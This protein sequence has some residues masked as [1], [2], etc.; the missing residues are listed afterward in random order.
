MA[1]IDRK[2]HCGIHNIVGPTLSRR[3]FIKAGGILAVGFTL[4]GPKVLK[5]ESGRPSAM[6]NSLDPTLSSSWIEIH[7]G[8]HA[9]DSHRQ[10]RLR[11][12]LYL[13]RVPANCG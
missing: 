3:Q 4:V 11:P 10:E 5:A 7:P 12:R 2:N 13:H 1:P 6:M 9:S 8:Q